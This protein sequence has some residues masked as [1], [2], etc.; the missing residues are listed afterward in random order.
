MLCVKVAVIV[1]RGGSCLAG[2]SWVSSVKSGEFAMRDSVNLCK[3]TFLQVML[4]QRKF[5][6]HQLELS[7]DEETVYS[8]LYA[9][10]RCV[11]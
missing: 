9:R 8:V 6:L 4:P 5:Q 7:E 11:Q 10:S 1:G 3:I 2:L